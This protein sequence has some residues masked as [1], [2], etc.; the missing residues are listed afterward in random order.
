M[1]KAIAFI[2]KEQCD[3]GSWY[4]RWGVNYLYGR[5]VSVKAVCRKVWLRGIDRKV[6]VVVV[7]AACHRLAVIAQ[8]VCTP[9]TARGVLLLSKI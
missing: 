7:A 3:D 5:L 2:R 6:K 9:N 4:G 8:A 1:R